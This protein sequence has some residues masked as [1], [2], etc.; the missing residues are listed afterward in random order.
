M[1]EVETSFNNLKDLEVKGSTQQAFTNAENIEESSAADAA[2]VETEKYQSMMKENQLDI[3][4]T[5]KE[6]QVKFVK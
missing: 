1:S 4:N 2:Q 3:E 5:D 6:D